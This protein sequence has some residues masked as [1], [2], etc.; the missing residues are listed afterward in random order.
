VEVVVF[1]LCVLV[2]VVV[3][4]LS[5]LVVVLVLRDSVVVVP[6]L[7]AQVL[8]VVDVELVVA[9]WIIS[10]EAEEPNARRAINKKRTTGPRL[11]RYLRLFFL[12]AKLYRIQ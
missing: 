3:V 11:V 2:V 5:V 4:D 10:K 8:L 6:Q 7:A 9:G 1:D 12:V